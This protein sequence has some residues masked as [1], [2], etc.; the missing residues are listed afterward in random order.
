MD[1]LPGR[2]HRRPVGGL[3]GTGL[4]RQ[5]VKVLTKSVFPQSPPNVYSLLR[6]GFPANKVNEATSSRLLVTLQHPKKG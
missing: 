5:E 2:L 1:C 3:A 6:I 4:G